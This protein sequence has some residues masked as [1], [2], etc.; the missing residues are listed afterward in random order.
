MRSLTLVAILAASAAGAMTVQLPAQYPGEP[1]EA[2]ALF[3]F[4]HE[5]L[6]AQRMPSNP[7]E[8]RPAAHAGRA[9]EIQATFAGRIVV[10]ADDP[11]KRSVRVRFQLP[12]GKS[13]LATS[14][15]EVRGLQSGEPVR[16]ILDVPT[17]SS[18]DAKFRLRAIV[19]EYDLPIQRAPTPAT[20]HAQPTRHAPPAA[21]P[22]PVTPP[23]T[24]P[25][26]ALPA[27]FRKQGPA[28]PALA[29]FA[30]PVN[31]GVPRPGKEGTWDPV[32]NIGI[33]IVE[34][35]K[36]DAWKGFA[37]KHNPRLVD[38][39]ADWIARWVLYY[40]ALNGVDHR[41]MFAMIKC[42]SDFNPHC[43]SRA[44]AVG[45]TQLMPCNLKDFKVVN[46][47]NV[48]DNIRAGIEHFK[49]MLDMWQGRNNYEQF[50]LGAASYNAGPN[51]VKRA[52][53]IPNIAETRNYVKK[54]G[55]LFY[56]LWKSGYP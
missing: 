52:G 5:S 53:G 56:S 12:N 4:A 23:T 38:W 1:D 33:P 10:N 43:V 25:N 18:Q 17:G 39:Q 41:L 15:S 42:E 26:M 44:G 35:S 11:Q 47:W 6:K 16:A 37:R 31:G 9:I 21:A 22:S 3:E 54:L 48:Q 24:Q 49:E 45:L 28:L 40:S 50:A 30:A 27:E 29:P 51:R 46:K 14:S 8:L 20:G 36:L 2:V 32:G 7:T 13:L 55:D 34:Q 19:R